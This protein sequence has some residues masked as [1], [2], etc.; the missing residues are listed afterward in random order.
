MEVTFLT[1]EGDPELAR[2][3]DEHIARFPER[4][5]DAYTYDLIVLGDVRATH[6][7]PGQLQT[8]EALVA[9]HGGAMIVVAGHKHM[10]AEYL[11]TPIGE[12]LPVWCEQG[13]WSEVSEDVYLELTDAGQESTFMTLADG[14]AQNRS[15]WAK[16][17]GLRRVAP[18]TGAKDGATVLA[19]LSDAI[20]AAERH[21]LIAWQRYGSGKVLFVGT[22]RLWRLRDKVGDLYHT[23]FWS[24][25]VQFL[26]LSRLL[27]ESKR[28]RLEI[29]PG[30]PEVGRPVEVFAAALDETYEPLGAPTLPVS[31]QRV[32]SDV[33]GRSVALKAVPN[34]PGLYHGLIVPR[35]TGQYR[36]TAAG[37]QAAQANVVDFAVTDTP[38]EQRQAAM[39]RDMLSKLA[40]RSGGTYLPIH[41]LGVLPEL[42]EGRSFTQRSVR[43][44]PLWDSWL[45]PLL[46]LVLVGVEWAWRRNKD[47]A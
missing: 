9:D 12:M 28:I 43:E 8:M 24:Q 16:V 2:A 33:E 1:T 32:G 26:S 45:V 4:L 46:L 23:R 18:V 13:S 17:N 30:R 44:V 47:L 41:R 42:L 36:I 37:D 31:V 40:A 5:A 29:G 22:D 35:R 21:P 25:A 20:G 27:G 15:V 11:N 34:L 14:E 38:P 3:S 19:T 39:Q 6:F 7:T 10:P